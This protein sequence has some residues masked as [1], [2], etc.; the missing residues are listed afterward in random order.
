MDAFYTLVDNHSLNEIF[1]FC[2]GLIVFLKMFG[3]A[4]EWIIRL[5]RDK[6]NLRTTSEK[7]YDEV[8]ENIAGV[9][10]SLEVI[11]EDVSDNN[12]MLGRIEERVDM[13]H[14]QEQQDIRAY[15]V[16]RHNYF[17]FDIGAI[18]EGSLT[19]IEARY[20]YYKSQ[21]GNS[22]IDNMMSDIR[23]LPYIPNTQLLKKPQS[24]VAKGAVSEN[25]LA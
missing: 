14:E 4:L 3:E 9:C 13:L 20:S 16:D 6:L 1:A 21:G 25:D 23:K 12:E 19:E 22:F 18:D 2:V 15:L 7:K 10:K 11:K 24:N 5:F 8:V 17:C